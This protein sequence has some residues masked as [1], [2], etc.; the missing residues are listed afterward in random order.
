MDGEEAST[1]L[2][3]DI[4]ISWSR[5]NGAEKISALLKEAELKFNAENPSA[6]IPLLANAYSL[7]NGLDD[8]SW[9]E[10]KSREILQL[11]KS[12]AGFW[13]EAI[14]DEK[15]YTP[16][17]NVKVS[18]A[19]VNRS[20]LNF[21]LEGV[22]LTY[23]TK[24]SLINQELQKGEIISLKKEIKIPEN[25]Q[26]SQPHWLKKKSEGN[27]FIVEDQLMR[28]LPVN[29]PPLMAHFR[30]SLDTSKFVFTTPVLSRERVP[31][32]GEV[33]YPVSIAPPVTVNFESSL[34]L[35][36]SNEKREIR[37]IIKNLKENSNGKLSL[38]AQDGWLI[39][40]AEIDFQL[41]KKSE[42]KQFI[43]IVKPPAG[44]DEAVLEAV[45]TVDDKTYRN[46]IV[47]IDYDHIPLQT[48]FPQAE[49]KLVRLNDIQRI[50]NTI[51]YIEGSG[52][53]IAIYLKELGFDVVYLKD[54][55]LS[56]G[57]L[58]SY[59]VIIAGIRTYNTNKRMDV[60]QDK[61]MEYVYNGGTYIVQY[62]T[63][64]KVYAEPGPFEFKISRDRVTE[65]DA[66]VKL[67]IPG[68]P[69]LSF[70]NRITEKD[71]EGWIQERGLYFPNEWD[72][73]YEPI[74]EMNDQGE[75]PKFGSLLYAKYG[76]GVFIYTGLSF[77]RELPAG[78]PGAYNLFINL[79]SAG[80]IIE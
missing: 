32:K 36:S 39:E 69:L 56:N 25:I 28:D 49:A 30:V 70:P 73:N 40:P 22:H 74:L 7:M 53:K 24:D 34:Y 14:V 15:V 51:G 55:D 17:D 45:L 37:L 61:L 33:Y 21:I 75:D 66:K 80:K 57:N 42:E 44:I 26:I 50:V 38:N 72:D 60:Y 3:D 64:G 2:L 59:D 58:S 63:L 48:V 13:V 79:I 77:F 23:Q 8:I 27:I 71:F 18:T 9:V 10:I 35:F 29:S 6:I 54:E 67:L 41:V 12:C 65:E 68:H 46:S 43:F 31:T 5:I 52:D 78:V 1:D 20:D 16:E 47:T 4:E 19:I 11:I 62:N 76:D